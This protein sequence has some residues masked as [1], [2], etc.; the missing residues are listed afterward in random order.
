[1]PLSDERVLDENPGLT[2]DDDRVSP[3]NITTHRSVRHYMKSLALSKGKR[4]FSQLNHF[5]LPCPLTPVRE[6]AGG[7]EPRWHLEG[8]REGLG[9]SGCGSRGSRRQQGLSLPQGPTSLGFLDVP[10]MHP[11]SCPLPKQI[12]NRF[13]TFVS[14]NQC[15][16]RLTVLLSWKEEQYKRDTTDSTQRSLDH[17]S[18]PTV[19]SYTN[20]PSAA[21]WVKGRGACI[22]ITR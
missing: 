21:C 12:Q 22:S 8:G 14:F 1:M 5:Y 2:S 9:A 4:D 3:T 15:S 20:I 18:D 10:R 17:S 13:P 16:E 11:G 7:Q 6:P 19:C